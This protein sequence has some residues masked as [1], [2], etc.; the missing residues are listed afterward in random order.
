MNNSRTNTLH[1]ILS[2]AN[3]HKEMQLDE[4]ITHLTEEHDEQT[5]KT[6]ICDVCLQVT[7][8]DVLKFGMEYF[9]TNGHYDELQKLIDK[10]AESANESNRKWAKVYQLSKDRYMKLDK[11]KILSPQD[12]IERANS[13]RTDEPA[14]ICVIEFLKLGVYNQLNEFGQIGNFLDKQ[15]GLFDQI[16]D[17]FLKK[18][19]QIR[20][21]QNLFVYHW[22][23]NELIIA[24][25][26]AFQIINL[27]TNSEVKSNMHISLGLTYTF[28]TYHQGMY[29]LNEALYIAKQ[30]KIYKNINRIQ[31]KNI[32]FLS[33]HFKQVEGI[34]TTDKSEQAHIEIAKGN[35]HEANKILKNME[36]N[37]P[38][39]LY[40]LGMATQDRNILLKS[41]KIFITRRS[42]YF[43]SRLPLQIIH[44]M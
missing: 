9:Y 12:V 43:F 32:P 38:F 35:L 14:L 28:D 27:T 6:M 7:S 33:A 20:L 10:N 18:S 8:D 36:I 13:I 31:N 23:R 40:Y 41:Y 42:D 4:L 39:K 2:S 26:Y 37:S 25:K 44:H 24:R 30:S 17:Q 15:P 11:V 19:F 34:T 22:F 1:E 5:A 29:H 3:T 21:Y 16:E